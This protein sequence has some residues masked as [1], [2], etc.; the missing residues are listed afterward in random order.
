MKTGECEVATTANK[1]TTNVGTSQQNQA[2]L[3]QTREQDN[4]DSRVIMAMDRQKEQRRARMSPPVLPTF[5]TSRNS[6]EK[7]VSPAQTASLSQQR[8]NATQTQAR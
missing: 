1:P 6:R 8:N 2:T 3:N 7:Q 5:S 4:I